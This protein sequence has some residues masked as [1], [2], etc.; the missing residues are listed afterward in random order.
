MGMLPSLKAKEIV[1]ALKKNGF[2]EDRQKGS[3][4]VLTHPE[5]KARAVVPVHSG[6]DVKKS[7]VRMIIND[8]RLSVED[9]IK[10]L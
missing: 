2:V 5:T 3:H 8:A 9:F 10:L 1:R 6:R 7:L 4:L